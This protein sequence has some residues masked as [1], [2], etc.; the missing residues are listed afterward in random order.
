MRPA[1][2]I[3]FAPLFKRRELV[4][5]KKVWVHGTAEKRTIR[6]DPRGSQ[7][8]DTLIHEMCHVNHP[9][10]SEKAVRQH[11]AGRLLRMN[12]KEKARLLRLLG[13][14]EIEGEKKT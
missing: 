12:W 6:I 8:L 4:G 13:A 11:T 14:A 1:I 7:L 10:W 3:V 9:G 5:G 2:K